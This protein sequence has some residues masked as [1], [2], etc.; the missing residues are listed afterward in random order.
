MNCGQINPGLLRLLLVKPTSMLMKKTI[1]V[2]VA[3]AA[4]WVVGGC[5][6]LLPQEESARVVAVNT[7]LVENSSYESSREYAGTL[8]E[9]TSTELCFEASGRVTSVRVREGQYVKAGQLLATVDNTTTRN[10]YNAAKASLDRAQDG[11]DRARQ[12]YEKGSLPEV[13]WV[14][15]QTQLDQARSVEEISRKNLENC[16]LYAPVSGTVCDKRIEVG[17]TVGPVVPVMRIVNMQGLYVKVSIPEIDINKVK[18]GD[19]AKVVVGAVGDTLYDAV[20]EE[21]NVDADPLSHSYM[22][23]MRVCGSTKGLLPGMVCRVKFAGERSEG[24]YE[25]P[26]RA[27]QLDNDGCRFVWVVRDSVAEKRRVV[28]SDLTATGVLVNSGLAEGDRVIVDGGQKVSTGTR[29]RENQ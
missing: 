26:N 8:E 19:R 3:V 4:M 29:V 14:E 11:Y 16:S 2:C 5:G 18:V 27:V 22:L 10:A 20:V 7:M 1:V 25:V 21:R 17:S 9:K 24:G 28:I 15:V 13:K 6:R 23:R 12:V